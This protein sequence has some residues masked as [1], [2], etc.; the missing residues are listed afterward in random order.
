[1]NKDSELTV[2]MPGRFVPFHNS[3]LKVIENLADDERVKKIVLPVCGPNAFYT[4][5]DFMAYEEKAS[6][7]RL[8]VRHLRKKII[9]FQADD[10]DDGPRWPS[11][12]EELSPVKF[13]LVMSGNPYTKKLFDR[14]GVATESISQ[15]YP[16]SA[17]LIRDLMVREVFDEVKSWHTLVPIGTKEILEAIKGDQRLARIHLHHPRPILTGDLIIPAEDYQN[18]AM[19][20]RKK[21]PYPG[22]WAHSGGHRDPYEL[23]KTTAMREGMEEAIDPQIHILTPTKVHWLGLYDKPFRD[24]R[25]DYVSHVYYCEPVPFKALRAADD[26]SD[27][28]VFSIFDLPPEREIAFDHLNMIKDYIKKRRFNGI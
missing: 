5:R 13:N 25:G 28:Q 1:M 18:I 8:S 14:A 6:A 11:Y 9:I 4:E 23:L 10:I 19:I 17:T 2:A 26:A 7:I 16:I 12:L 15:Q 21:W 27:F 3:H 22:R 20:K 24:P